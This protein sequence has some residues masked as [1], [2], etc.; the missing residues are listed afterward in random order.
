M[1]EL[2]FEETVARMYRESV[3]MYGTE[4]VERQLAFDDAIGKAMNL[5]RSGAMTAPVEMAIRAALEKADDRD[6]RHADNIIKRIV[7]GERSL[8]TPSGDPAL[9]VVVKLGKGLRKAWRDINDED[10]LL[11][12]ELRGKNVRTVVESF[13]S[14]KGDVQALMPALVAHGTVGAAVE[15]GAF[16]QAVAA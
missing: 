5:V 9:D 6:S 16:T 3:A 1:P 10:L 13:E 11:M 4:G 14:W 15:S 12:T 8:F 7:A 2:D